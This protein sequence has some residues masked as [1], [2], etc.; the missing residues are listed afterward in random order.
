MISMQ[1]NNAIN[2]KMRR[3]VRFWRSLVLT[4]G[5]LV[6]AILAGTII[7][8]VAFFIECSLTAPMR[9]GAALG[10]TAARQDT[11][12]KQY[13]RGGQKVATSHEHARFVKEL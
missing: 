5:A 11:P 2:A 6:A 13:W 8:T 12:I 3:P 1:L 7:G 4:A 10:R 9:A